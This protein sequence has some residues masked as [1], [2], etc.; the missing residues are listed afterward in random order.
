MRASK[1]RASYRRPG[2][3]RFTA[4]VAVAG[5][6]VAGTAATGMHTIGQGETLSQIAAD[7]GVTTAELAEANDIDDVDRV[8]AGQVLALPDEVADDS[9]DG[10]KDKDGKDKDRK[11]GTDSAPATPV[12]FHTVVAGDT[13][14]A[15]ARTYGVTVVA[16]AEAN[17]IDDIHRIR[18][19][20][21]LA[22]EGA[23]S[24]RTPAEVTARASGGGV[25]TSRFPARLQAS[26]ERLALVPIFERWA[27]EYGAPLD[28]LMAMTWLESGWQDDVVSSAGAM[29]IG[30]IMPDT[31]TWM[32]D[33]LIGVPLDPFD[34]NDSIR[35]SARYLR[36]LLDRTDGDAATALA[37]YYQGL[38]AVQT[39]GIFPSTRA[40]VANVLTFRDEYF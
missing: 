31:V 5:V 8:V 14:S 24:G 19:G 9:K 40:Y 22:I 3:Q 33:V 28:L 1:Y 21:E 37:G 10:K 20:D 7:H 12:G 39:S 11:E 25:D 29:G 30:Q 35:M 4:L 17:G 26:P 15:I 13:L 27:A 18:V 16:L 6:A 2:R 38:G 32:E 36:W 23:G 34:A